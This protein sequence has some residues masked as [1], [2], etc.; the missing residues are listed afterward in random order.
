MTISRS[1]EYFS[2]K[3]TLSESQEGVNFAKGLRLPGIN[4]IPQN[5]FS[6]S[7]GRLNHFQQEVEVE[8]ME[9]SVCLQ[10]EE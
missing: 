3:I 9:K 8:L 5:S 1:F 2:E 4:Y 7:Y 10:H 6:L